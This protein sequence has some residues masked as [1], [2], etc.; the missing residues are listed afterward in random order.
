MGYKHIFVVSP[1]SELEKRK[2]L[3]ASLGQ[4]LGVSFIAQ[5]NLASAK[6]V[7]KILFCTSASILL[8]NNTPM[9]AIVFP[10]KT[11]SLTNIRIDLCDLP[12]VSPLIRGASFL[13]IQS[14]HPSAI[15]VELGDAILAKVNDTPIWVRR[16]TS[17]AI[18]ELA[19]AS[20]PELG[21]NEILKDRFRDGNAFSLLTLLHFVRSV[22]EKRGYVSPPLR[23]AF[24]IDDPNLRSASYGCIHFPTLVEIAKRHNFHVVLAT[25]PLDMS[26]ISK[27]VGYFAC[28]HR[29]QLSLAVHGNNHI[30]VELDRLTSPTAELA[31]MA[32][33]LK[34]KKYF[35]NRYGLPV[36]KV[37][38]PPH[39]VCSRSILGVLR[40]LGFEAVYV[41]KPEPWLQHQH[42]EFSS[43]N[44]LQRWFPADYI[45]GMP[46]IHREKK[47]SDNF[48][49]DALL[50]QPLIAYF[51]HDD[52]AD[53]YER[54]CELA[55]TINQLG[56]VQWQPLDEIARANYQVQID[57]ETLQIRPFSRVIDVQ[58]PEG[59]N[60]VVMDI[61]D[62]ANLM[63]GTSINLGGIEYPIV[64]IEA[65]Y[66]TTPIPVSNGNVIRFTLQDPIAP[67]LEEIP[68][69]QFSLYPI[70][71]RSLTETRDRLYPF[72]YRFRK[73]F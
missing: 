18:N 70:I 45:D 46:I 32:Q 22:L 67:Q 35:E 38:I 1:E 44:L 28:Q 72:F 11:E 29:R 42:Q 8:D 73:L 36:S 49:F 48:R 52:F 7:A 21:D 25:I 68:T 5:S 47:T 60:R 31:S 41:S 71:R 64:Q 61:P 23:A 6:P 15:P 53:G 56:N 55:E 51:H 26:W 30:H 58:I 34:R 9:L 54:L 10:N 40:T 4:A 39:E 24:I 37:M 12:V 66:G 2:R 20:L 17:G 19:C 16:G 3:F 65:G 59:I 50:G 27:K 33:A 62:T 14:W 43:R 63:E 57:E 69:P 13:E